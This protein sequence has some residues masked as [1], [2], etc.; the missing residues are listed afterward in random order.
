MSS[1]DGPH[2]SRAHAPF[3]AFAGRPVSLLQQHPGRSSQHQVQSLE[4]PGQTGQV[5]PARQPRTRR[6]RKN[7]AFSL[8]RTTRLRARMWVRKDCGPVRKAFIPAR[9]THPR[10]NPASGATVHRAANRRHST[11]VPSQR[12]GG[13][14]VSTPGRALSETQPMPRLEPSTPHRFVAVMQQARTVMPA[15]DGLGQ[16]GAGGGGRLQTPP[17]TVPQVPV[18]ASAQQA[19]GSMKPGTWGVT[20][21]AAP[22]STPD[23]AGAAAAPAPGR[24]GAP[25]PP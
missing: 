3:M 8:R 25:A 2:A 18:A 24:A 4:R 22:H 1:L 21:R 11:S 23:P 15:S 17:L 12:V 5:A 7:P 16:F 19:G 10:D 6:G 20:Q 14:P 9:H 13:M